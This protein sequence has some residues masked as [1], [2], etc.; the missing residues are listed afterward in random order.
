MATA[1]NSSRFQDA[2]CRVYADLFLTDTEWA[3]AAVCWT[4]EGLSAEMLPRITNVL[5]DHE[6]AECDAIGRA[7]GEVGIGHTKA[8]IVAFLSGSVAN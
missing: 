7:C 5:R 1:S 3:Y 2:L 4:P 6:V 8:E